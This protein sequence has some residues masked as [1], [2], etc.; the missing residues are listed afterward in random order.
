[1]TAKTDSPIQTVGIAGRGAI[2][3]LYGMQM[4]SGGVEPWYIADEKRIWRYRQDPV[5]V[6]GIPQTF[7]YLQPGTTGNE[8]AGDSHA[9]P[10]LDLVLI[11]TKASGLEGALEEIAPF[12]DDHT[13]ILSCL[14]GITSEEIVRERY[15][16]N[17]ILRTIVQGMDTVYLQGECRYS[18]IGEI[19]TGSDGP[20]Q[21]TAVRQVKAFFDSIG[22]PC[23]IC[24]D[25]VRE[26]WNKL[27]LNCGV[28]QICAVY[29][30]GYAGAVGEHRELFVRVMEE[31]RQ[32]ALARGIH[33]GTEDIDRWLTV[34]EALDGKWGG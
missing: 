21:E 17:T 32:V 12:V 2:G 29:G 7:R 18:H 24:E 5:P 27:M 14:N 9:G 11:M 19:L 30:C 28:N 31:V 6:N 25:I 3:L 23:R 13:I 34:C 22:M 26:Q 20:G 15:P 4:R 8:S 16:G 1:M 10:A 33:L